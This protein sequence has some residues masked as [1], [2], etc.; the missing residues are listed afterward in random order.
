MAKK[1]NLEKEFE[2]FTLRTDGGQANYGDARTASSRLAIV[3]IALT[4]V[5][6]IVGVI[7]SAHDPRALMTSSSE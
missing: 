2:R 6:L 7:H 1:D 5:I 4:V 3:N